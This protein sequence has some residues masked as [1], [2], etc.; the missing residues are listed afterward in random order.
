MK[1]FAA[2]LLSLL[3]IPCFYAQQQGTATENVTA[4]VDSFH[5]SLES[6]RARFGNRPKSDI[7]KSLVKTTDYVNFLDKLFRAG[8]P[9]PQEYLEGITLDADLLKKLAAQKSS[10]AAQRTNLYEGLKEV[11]SDLALKVSGPRDGNGNVARVVRVIVRAKKGDQELSAYEVWYVPKGWAK[12]QTAFKRFD[13]LTNPANPPSMNL[14]PGNYLIWLTK[15]QAVTARQP[16]SLG[17]DSV[18][19]REIDVPIP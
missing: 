17:A 19:R 6:L 7:A 16:L 14:A 3:F 13:G 18:D 2:L 15:D 9:F 12:E 1:T 11:E 4:V 5:D 8:T 10:T